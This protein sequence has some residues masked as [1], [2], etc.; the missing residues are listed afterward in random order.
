MSDKTL[1]YHKINQNKEQLMDAIG[2]L[3][4]WKNKRTLNGMRAW[5]NIYSGSANMTEDDIQEALDL[6]KIQDVME[7]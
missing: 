7:S 1:K 5:M 3:K 6:A 4:N 2:F